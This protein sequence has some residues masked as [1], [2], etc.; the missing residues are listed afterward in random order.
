[1][2]NSFGSTSCTQYQRFLVLRFQ[3]WLNRL[4][5]SHNIRVISDQFDF[6]F[7]G[8]DDF[9]HVYGTDGGCIRI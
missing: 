2:I 1:M 6:P 4:G 9:N 3:Q 7:S 8:A 5:K